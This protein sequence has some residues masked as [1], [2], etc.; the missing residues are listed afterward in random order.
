M[1]W[2]RIA[3]ACAIAMAAV[4][5]PADATDPDPIKEPGTLTAV[6]IDEPIRI[7]GRLDDAAWDR[8]VVVDRFTQILPEE[9]AP[10][11]ERTEAR[12][13]YDAEALYVGVRLWD[14][15]PVSS[16]LGR[17]DMAIGGDSD[18][19]GLMLD[20][21]LDRRTAFGFDVNPA[22]VK[23]DL[24]KTVESDD[25]SWDAVWEVATQVDADGW[26]V[27]YR[28][29]FS[30]LRFRDGE[31]QTWGI[32]LERLIA[33]TGEYATSTFIP[34]DEQGGVPSYG[35]LTGLES[36]TTGK[37]LEARPYASFRTLTA[38]P[39]AAHQPAA[40]VDLRYRV[41][42]E[43]TLNATLNPDFGQVELDPAVVNLSAFETFYDER[44]PFFVEGAGVFAFG[45]G[46]VG[47]GSALDGLFYSRRIGRRPQL[48]VDGDAPDATTILGAA[49]LTGRAGGWDLGVLEAATQAEWVPSLGDGAPATADAL[50]EPFTNY[51]VA[52]ADRRIR[53]GR[54]A[55]GGLFA[56]VNR[57]L[58]TDAA[59]DRLASAAYTG[60]LDFRHE[61]AD[62][63]WRL[64]GFA[65][66][67]HVRGDA[68][69]ITRL[70]NSPARYYG[71]PDA[72]YLT[73][74]PSATSLSGWA[75]QL[76][77]M[78][79]AGRHWR[80]DVGVFAASPGYET[81]ALGFLTRGDIR[82]VNGS[83]TYLDTE[84]GEMVRSYRVIGQAI[85]SENFG[86]DNLQDILALAGV[87]QLQNFW[88]ATVVGNYM[89]E[90][91][92]DRAARGGPSILEPALSILDVT[93]ESDPRRAIM[94]SANV[95]YIGA[96][97]GG[98][99]RTAS[100]SA[101]LRPAPWWRLE[102]GPRV[103][104]NQVMSKYVD[105]VDDPAA[106]STYGRRYLFAD[107]DQTTVSLDT[108]LDVTFSP[109][110]TLELFARPFVS[111]VTY[112]DLVQLATPR[113]RSFE[114]YE[115]T[116]PDPDRDFTLRSLRGNAVLR[117]E[118]RPGSTLYV[119]WQQRREDTE[120]G[121]GEFQLDEDA[122]ALF[123]TR[124]D[125]VLMI[126]AEYWLNF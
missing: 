80:G 16:R 25:N 5:A 9:G 76:Q 41:T 42:S 47:P 29:P 50:A 93:V 7:D 116:D 69:A 39:G 84:P 94:G 61:W 89:F 3:G 37:R 126:K 71:R 122:D 124:P 21:D 59:V 57:D 95:Q 91:F 120:L 88:S 18:W 4:V 115:G 56:A 74:D 33:R 123:R 20:S 6:R 99:T 55:L 110:L 11:S 68:D 86:G 104:R 24:I 87:W 8:A 17:R 101:T 92:E 15:H 60:G 85:H 90:S 79:Q 97:D 77:L 14:R 22:G 26:T 28:V 112:G 105:V 63:T 75:G 35:Q 64:S 125:N 48:P 65:A 19:F 103:S 62:R 118:W 113:T 67:S 27:E 107:L 2:T 83:V 36:L 31:E 119:A 12:I 108:R 70:Q 73:L 78:K 45:R 23:R 34:A 1:R 30:Q 96:E 81:N 102:V 44:R 117:W 54:S 51:F 49:K 38:G 46:A 53:D 109:S 114:A 98:G 10:A 66:G 32:Q 40:G 58:E 13:L 82:G 106:T 100:V 52:R 43:L 72:D 121:V 111:S